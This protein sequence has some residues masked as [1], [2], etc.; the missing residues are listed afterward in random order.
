MPLPTHEPF[1]ELP[2]AKQKLVM[3]LGGILRLADALDRT[4]TG[5]VKRVAASVADD[6]IR[7]LVEAK[8]NWDAERGMVEVKRDLLERVA[9]RPVRCRAA[10]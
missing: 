8:G 10:D 1:Q 7:L 4:H 2:E 6:E 5:R 9:E 3:I